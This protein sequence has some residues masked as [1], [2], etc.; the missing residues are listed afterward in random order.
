MAENVTV[1][2]L[3]VTTTAIGGDKLI[4]NKG[5]SKTS[6]IDFEDLIKGLATGGDDGGGFGF[7]PMFYNFPDTFKL[8]MDG[9]TGTAEDG[10]YSNIYPSS[11]DVRAPMPENAD[12][13]LITF[14][15]SASITS[16]NKSNSGVVFAQYGR[17]LTIRGGNVTVA[18]GGASP[19]EISMGANL[20][21]YHPTTSSSTPGGIERYRVDQR[22]TK[23]SILTFDPG[24]DLIFNITGR[25]KRAKYCTTG[26]SGG[27][28]ILYP[29]NSKAIEL[30]QVVDFVNAQNS[31]LEDEETPEST[32]EERDYENS[33]TIKEKMRALITI[34]DMT[35]RYDSDLAPSKI[36][37]IEAVL[38][39]IFKLKRDTTKNYLQMDSILDS[40]YEELYLIDDV[41]FKF[42]WE[43]GNYRASFL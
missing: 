34:C 31:S 20:E 29:F 39:K 3:P 15:Y 23:F 6:K 41:A 7:A 32:I 14:Q 35:I 33:L 10:Q 22:N 1:R 17:A 9:W 21:M 26:C 37:E 24:A 12:M 30:A 11:Q 5:D 18:A 27:R 8:T 40:Y 38:E 13:A 36:P 25:L 43:T 28:F 42:P 4:I 2:D 16:K 19:G